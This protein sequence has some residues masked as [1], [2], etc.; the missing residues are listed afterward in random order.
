MDNTEIK[1]AQDIKE[2]I[3]KASGNLL[4]DLALLLSTTLFFIISA[5]SFIRLEDS[6]QVIG[7]AVA[8]TLIATC[9]CLAEM[10]HSTKTLK[11]LKEC[12]EASEAKLIDIE[13]LTYAY[14]HT[15]I[16]IMAFCSCLMSLVNI[17]S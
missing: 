13:P 16:A 17:Y 2:K 6:R 15:A 5:I 12:K 14:F 8:L 3:S 7:S 9:V 10:L 4:Y 1:N 11:K